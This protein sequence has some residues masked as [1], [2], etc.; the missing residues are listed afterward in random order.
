MNLESDQC[1][2]RFMVCSQLLICIRNHHATPFGP[3][4]NL[5]LRDFEILH[6]HNFLVESRGIE[7]RL[8]DDVGKIRPGETR[9]SSRDDVDVDRRIHGDLPGV[10]FQYPF[11]SLHVRSAHDRDGRSDRV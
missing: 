7:G 5:V 6:R 4:E 10:N 1:M 8:I 9:G 3:H 11:S 2:T